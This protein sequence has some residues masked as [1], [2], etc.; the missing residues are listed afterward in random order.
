V[1]ARRGRGHDKARRARRGKGEGAIHPQD[2]YHGEPGR[3]A[4]GH[5]RAR[6]GQCDRG[7]RREARPCARE[8]GRARAR[9]RE[10]GCTMRLMEPTHA[11]CALI[12]SQ[13]SRL[14]Y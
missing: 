8:P 11:S 3:R 1:G 7:E 4:G 14:D 2:N 5:G 13:M 9:I 12:P 10:A 6:Q